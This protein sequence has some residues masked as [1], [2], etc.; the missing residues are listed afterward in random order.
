MC[1]NSYEFEHKNIRS[2]IKV[3]WIILLQCKI[4]ELASVD[5]ATIMLV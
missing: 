3:I 4:T 5:V 2:S 1:L